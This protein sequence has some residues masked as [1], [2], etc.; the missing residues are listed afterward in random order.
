MMS[1]KARF[2]VVLTTS[3]KP[4]EAGATP[5]HPPQRRKSLICLKQ[6]VDYEHAIRRSNRPGARSEIPRSHGVQMQ[7][8]FDVITRRGTRQRPGSRTRGATGATG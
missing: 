2:R 3:E 4:I 6:P 5:A 1:G 8:S 7:G